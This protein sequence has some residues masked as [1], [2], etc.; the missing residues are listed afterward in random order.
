MWL[1]ILLFFFAYWLLYSSHYPFARPL[2][3]AAEDENVSSLPPSSTATKHALPY[4]FSLIKNGPRNVTVSASY[5]GSW[6][7]GWD[8]DDRYAFGDDRVF[9][10]DDCFGKPD[11]SKLRAEGRPLHNYVRRRLDPSFIAHGFQFYF[12]CDRDRIRGLYACPAGQKAF[13][14]EECYP[15]DI[16][17]ADMEN[18][19]TFPDPS[20]KSYYRVCVDGKSIRK[21]CKPDTFFWTD[22]CRSARD[23][24]S[25]TNFFHINA[26][27]YIRC[28]GD[29]SIVEECPENTARLASW[30]ACDA[31]VCVGVPDEFRKPMAEI[32]SG[33]F[34]YSPGYYVCRDHRVAETITCPSEWNPAKS[35]G[36]DLTHLPKVFDLRRRACAVPSLC[37]NVRPSDPSTVVVPVHEFTK[38]VPEW[39]YSR[40]FDS[41]VGFRCSEDGKKTRFAL[42]PGQRIVDHTVKWA[43]DYDA[44]TRIPVGDRIDA[45]YDCEA[46]KTIDCGPESVFDGERCKKRLAR[47]HS[48]KNFPFFRT[49]GLSHRNDWMEPFE[50]KARPQALA[51]SEEDDFVSQYD[52]RSDPDCVAYAFLKQMPRNRFFFL[53][54]GKHICRYNPHLDKIVKKTYDIGPR[55][56]HFWSQRLVPLTEEDEDCHFGHK[57]ESGDF[58]MDSTVYVTCD[59]RQPFVFCPSAST[60][61][62]DRVGKDGPCACVPD[63]A[64]H[65][66]LAVDGTHTFLTTQIEQIHVEKESSYEIDDGKTSSIEYDNDDGFRTVVALTLDETFKFWS[67][68][69]YTVYYRRL[70]TYPPNVFLE[71][72]TLTTGSHFPHLGYWI[73]KM[74][75]TDRPLALPKHDIEE[76]I[77]YK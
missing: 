31:D 42:E 77:G 34:V 59:T 74:K 43:C 19:R 33:P 39:H 47:A 50:A 11:G 44:A 45:Y 24:C 17:T 27:K 7:F 54:D 8:D 61:K 68:R 64:V 29:R 6:T 14:D 37:E 20:D 48:F 32:S 60:R 12:H 75:E 65:S 18:G 23:I 49:G 3:T 4:S 36:D 30:S 73:R 52:V 22:R 1:V 38:R 51:V 69:P 76:S 62:I 66:I 71:N 56:L 58:F 67:D 5:G 21:R 40:I 53:P 28:D 16:C 70:P 63:D 46:K 2:A 26:K 15:V 72:Q 10:T 13:R 35:R 41:T 55:K 9:E 57:L 25:E